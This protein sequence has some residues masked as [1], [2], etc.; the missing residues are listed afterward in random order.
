MQNDAFKR[1]SK[2]LQ[3]ALVIPV[4][5]IN[6]K[7]KKSM[8][9]G[10]G[11]LFPNSNNFPN[12]HHHPHPHHPHHHT[13]SH[14]SKRPVGLPGL[15]MADLKKD[16]SGATTTAAGVM[17]NGGGI[18]ADVLKSERAWDVITAT[19]TGGTGGA[20]GRGFSHQGSADLVIPG[21]DFLK[22][23]YYNPNEATGLA[24]VKLMQ[25]TN[26]AT[27]KLFDIEC[28]LRIGN[29]E[30]TSHPARSF[31]DNP[32][33]TAT[34][35]EVFLFDVEEAFQLEIEVTGTPI[36]TK[37][38]T[39]A[40]FSNTQS[41]NLGYL[42]LPLT[43][44][45]LEKSVRTYKL[46][47]SINTTGDGS[48]TMASAA[49]IKAQSKEK[50]DCE[51]VVM[52]G[53]HVLEEPVDDRSW[54][55]EVLFEG[56]LT[57]MTRGLRMSAWKRYWAVLQGNAV[58]LYDVEYQTKRDP[59][60]TIPLGH[61]LS[62]QPPDYDKVDVGS[63]G[64]ALVISPTGIDMTSASEF[65][66]ASNMDNN[67]YAFTDSAHLHESWNVQLERA[68][69]MYREGMARREE[70]LE[71]KRNRSQRRT[72]EEEVKEEEGLGRLEL[73]DMRFVS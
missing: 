16:M 53:V 51:I 27:S 10:N 47:R 9:G 3:E 72:T 43:L 20:D 24:L 33:N 37:F 65:D 22:T 1:F 30:R 19:G 70:I 71:A 73:I 42:H 67:I 8:V 31:K 48:Q 69:E 29:V 14:N 40:G 63:N 49:A 21:R 15:T 60:T 6:K 25:I 17:M 7:T 50:I 18:G 23:G 61:I 34:M 59:I 56:H 5:Y 28:S 52:I 68:M 26:R 39:M 13:S 44:E 11:D 12:S 54:E 46:R 38:G 62:V 4:N 35:N 32:G 66:R 58:K 36:A 57:V 45:P 2:D 41:V 55:N 64:F